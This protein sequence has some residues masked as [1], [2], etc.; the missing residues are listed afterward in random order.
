M[1]VIVGLLVLIVVVAVGFTGVHGNAGSAHLLTENFA[2]F[3]YHVSGST[4][5]LLLFGMAVGAAAML[6]LSVVLAGARH[7]APP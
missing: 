3:G 7:S 6:G 2:V 4:G 1:I 5:T